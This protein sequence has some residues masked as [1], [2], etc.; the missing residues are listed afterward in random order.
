MTTRGKEALRG[1]FEVR[2]IKLICLQLKEKMNYY[3]GG[4]EEQRGG[5][6]KWFYWLHWFYRLNCLKA[7]TNKKPIKR[8]E[9]ISTN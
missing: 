6:L 8:I 9:P 3:E 5:W 7:A 2:E 1:W 4:A